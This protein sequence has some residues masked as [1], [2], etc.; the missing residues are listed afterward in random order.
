MIIRI[1]TCALFLRMRESLA[2]DRI[3]HQLV[4]NVSFVDF[5]LTDW[6]SGDIHLA[7]FPRTSVS[8]VVA[9]AFF[10]IPPCFLLLR[11]SH[12]FVR[13][14][15]AAFHFFRKLSREKNDNVVSWRVALLRFNSHRFQ[16][17]YKT[18]SD[19]SAEVKAFLQMFGSSQGC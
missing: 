15:Q 2:S 19:L 9:Q 7:S 6:I 11:P 17:W 18:S 16:S 12:S 8:E 10:F 14:P 4:P 13:A 3:T 1:D 5:L